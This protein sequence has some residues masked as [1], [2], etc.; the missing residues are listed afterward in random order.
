MLCCRK[1]RIERNTG[2]S[3]NCQESQMR[4]LNQYSA[5]ETFNYS[6]KT[7][8]WGK[9]WLSAVP[10]I[11]LLQLSSKVHEFKHFW[12]TELCLNHLRILRQSLN[13]CRMGWLTDTLNDQF[14]VTRDKVTSKS[15]MSVWCL[16]ITSLS[17][18][19]QV[20]VMKFTYNF[21]PPFLRNKT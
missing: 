21:F 10:T 18:F 5:Q 6:F 19:P 13:L 9:N 15:Q 4:F 12:W 16:A 20:K 1:C 11:H 7:A 3:E 8:A 14:V 2:K 17:L